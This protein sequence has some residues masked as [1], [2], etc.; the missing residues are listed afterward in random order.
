MGR[1]L[2]VRAPLLCWLVICHLK[3]AIPAASASGFLPATFAIAE[4]DPIDDLSSW[5]HQ[6]C[7]YVK[8]DESRPPSDGSI[9]ARDYTALQFVL[10]Y[11]TFGVRP[12]LTKIEIINARLIVVQCLKL[13]AVEPNGLDQ[14][15]ALALEVSL[16]SLQTDLGS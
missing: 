13:L 14:E 1:T 2:I 5:L 6:L 8:C 9:S 16:V 4:S 3:C 10:A 7:Y 15:I 12:E 11:D